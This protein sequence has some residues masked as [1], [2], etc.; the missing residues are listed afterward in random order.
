M[1]Q[2]MPDW[3]GILPVVALGLFLL[4][5]CAVMGQRSGY[6]DAKKYYADDGKLTFK[7]SWMGLYGYSYMREWERY[8]LERARAERNKQ[9]LENY[10]KK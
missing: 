9:L 7:T 10:F 1:I 6:R 3:V 4:P 2:R 5:G 8:K